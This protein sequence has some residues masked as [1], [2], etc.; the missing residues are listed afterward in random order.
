M[1]AALALIADV[2]TLGWWIGKLGIARLCVLSQLAS[3][4][5]YFLLS[6]VG[7]SAGPNPWVYVAIAMG[8]IV[9][10][11]RFVVLSRLP[12]LES[13]TAAV[14]LY[15]MTLASMVLIPTV[16]QLLMQAGRPQD[17]PKFI[18]YTSSF[19]SVNRAIAAYPL[20]PLAGQEQQGNVPIGT[21]LQ[22]NAGLALLSCIFYLL[23]YP[24]LAPK[25]Q[26]YTPDSFRF[27]LDLR[28]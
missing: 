5:G 24:K 3:C 19:M 28:S 23:L 22:A 27:T 11:S 26:V 21:Y 7:I 8:K 10:L 4:I 6:T 15:F 1:L 13:I 20:L 18:G 25:K 14:M 9:M 17:I 16:M 12:H 2:M